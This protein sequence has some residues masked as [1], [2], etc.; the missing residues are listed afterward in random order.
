MRLGVRSFSFSVLAAATAAGCISPSESD[1]VNI[2]D[3]SVIYEIN[4]LLLQDEYIDTTH[5]A[6][7]FALTWL[8]SQGFIGYNCFGLKPTTPTDTTGTFV[9]GW[10]GPNTGRLERRN[11]GTIDTVA[12]YFI[13]QSPPGT[14]GT[15]VVD[16]TG[17]LTLTFAN[18]TRNRYFAP[19]AVIR[20]YGDT[21]E[22]RA[23]IRVQG[24]SVRDLWHVYWTY[25]QGCP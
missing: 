14:H 20:L 10:A 1:Q 17:K 12:G 18:G 22:S 21:I 25:S 9:F 15:Y 16:A 11:N 4:P 6:G 5:A 2:P 23:D 7:S 8:T 13:D 24:D 3:G 19:N